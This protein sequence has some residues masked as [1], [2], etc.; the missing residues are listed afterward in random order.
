MQ[1]CVQRMITKTKKGESVSSKLWMKPYKEF[2]NDS[3][4][5]EYS[6]VTPF[7]LPTGYTITEFKNETDLQKNLDEILPPK[8]VFL[9][10]YF[11]LQDS[12]NIF[13]LQPKER[14]EIFKH[15]F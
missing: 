2:N 14:L 13:E 5:V 9:G 11:L 12:D 3:N 15:V 10:T 4:I 7:E 1:Y 6:D 8:E